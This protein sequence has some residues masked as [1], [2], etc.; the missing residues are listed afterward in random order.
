MSFRQ[1]Q[2]G[3]VLRY[4]ASV[5]GVAAGTW[6]IS[7]VLPHYHIANIFML[8][9]LVV[10]ALAVF[11]GS[12]PAFVASVLSFL[13]FDWFFVPPVGHWTVSDPDE[14]SALFLFLLVAAITGQLAAGLRRRAEEA[15]RRARETSTLYELSMAIL[16]D[17]RLER[18][19]QVIAER[20]LM[21][22]G[23]RNVAVLLLG[24]SGRL[25]VATK[26]GD[27]LDSRERE[28]REVS[29]H[30]A[31]VAGHLVSDLPSDETPA[32]S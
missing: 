30:W 32:P 12:G 6:L 27:A 26:V 18:V 16:G 7:L 24:P 22:V 10:L 5:V 14:W 23:L 13:A 9:L 19:L 1:G 28:E 4:G 21:T 11:A 31:I 25:E 15:R 8:Y 17:A 2:L 29:G 3:A 20:M